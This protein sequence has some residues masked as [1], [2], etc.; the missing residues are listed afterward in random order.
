MGLILLLLGVLGA[1]WVIWGMPRPVTA[2]AKVDVFL[3]YILV[4]GAGGYGV[5]HFVMH[6]FSAGGC[7]TDGLVYRTISGGTGDGSSWG[8]CF[9]SD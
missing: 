2:V 4:F 3:S 6:A 8:R 7:C 1:L 5:Y 9:S